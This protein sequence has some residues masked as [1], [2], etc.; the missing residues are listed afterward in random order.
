MDLLCV[1]HTTREDGVVGGGSPGAFVLVRRGSHTV[2]TNTL[3]GSKQGKAR[4][5]V[6]CCVGYVLSRGCS[7][8]ALLR[9][10]I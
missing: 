2:F 3:G 9:E 4:H 5:E 10:D 8:K 7:G 1:V 6:S